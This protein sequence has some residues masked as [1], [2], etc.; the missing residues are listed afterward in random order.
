MRILVLDDDKNRHRTFKSNLIGYIVHHVYTVDDARAALNEHVFDVLYLD[1]DLNDHES[2]SVDYSGGYGGPREMTGLDVAR[3]VSLQCE[4]DPKKTPQLVV[5]HSFNFAG[6]K[7]IA[8]E[9]R[10][11]VPQ[12]VIQ[13]FHEK[14]GLD[15]AWMVD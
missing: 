11:T 12:V 4:R 5:V 13:K 3:Y 15:L 1:H 2:R 9:L 14:I 7:A 8:D 6:A 10:G